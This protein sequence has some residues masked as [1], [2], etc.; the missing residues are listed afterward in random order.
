MYLFAV[1]AQNCSQQESKYGT[2]GAVAIDRHGHLACATSTGGM[3]GKLPGRVGD[4][5][6]VGCGGYCDDSSG[7]SS[8]TGHGE[9][10]ARVCL[11]YQIVGLMQSGVGP[12]DATEQAITK[13]NQKTGGDG[14]AITLS[15]KGEVGIYFNSKRMAWAYARKRELHY[16]IDRNEDEIENL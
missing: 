13:M 6:L 14:G 2:V 11:C 10:I 8:A 7:A 3:T 4:T 9:S 5:P 1:L 12:Q 16:G 15:N